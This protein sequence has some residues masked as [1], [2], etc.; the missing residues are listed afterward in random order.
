MRQVIHDKEVKICICG[1][2]NKTVIRNAK[3]RAAAW[4]G[5]TIVICFT[6]VLI[7]DPEV[8][9]TDIDFKSWLTYGCVAYCVIGV[10]YKTVKYKLAKH[11]LHCSF[12]RD[13]LDIV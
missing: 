11:S 3:R 6:V 12:R 4:M 10:S 2:S 5:T 1:K 9:F 13:F 7:F 8:I